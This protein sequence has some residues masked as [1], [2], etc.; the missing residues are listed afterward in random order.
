MMIIAM[1]T[2]MKV[3]HINFQNDGDD[4]GNNGE[5]DNDYN[6]DN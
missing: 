4:D 2:M 1:A 3:M 6:N 5:E